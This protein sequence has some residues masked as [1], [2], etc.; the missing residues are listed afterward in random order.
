MEGRGGLRGASGALTWRLPRAPAQAGAPERGTSTHIRDGAES[1]PGEGAPARLIPPWDPRVPLPRQRP[2]PRPA[3]RTEGAAR[4]K[5]AARKET[6]A[7]SFPRRDPLGSQSATS[8][9]CAAPSALR[10]SEARGGCSW[11]GLDGS[12]TAEGRARLG[13]V[14]SARHQRPAGVPPEGAFAPQYQSQ[15]CGGLSRLRSLGL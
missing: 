9:R 2:G 1:G 7:Q 4:R 11:S 8:G 14:G 15:K 12:P 6:R 5:R 3:P 10:A 13:R